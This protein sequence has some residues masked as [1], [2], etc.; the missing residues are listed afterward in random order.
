MPAFAAGMAIVQNAI[1]FTRD[2]VNKLDE[3]IADSKYYKVL[4]IH[5]EFDSDGDL[6]YRAC[7][8]QLLDITYNGA[9]TPVQMTLTIEADSLNPTWGTT[10]PAPGAVDHNEGAN[11][12]VTASPTE[13]HALDY[14]ILDD[15]AAGSD[16]P[17]IVAMDSDHTLRPVWK[18]GGG[19]D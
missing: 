16:N 4:D 15:E 14:W 13:G 9:A 8:L 6:V 17:T 19:S 11:V 5:E 12:V 7:H 3:I 1:L 10:T 2:T 18:E